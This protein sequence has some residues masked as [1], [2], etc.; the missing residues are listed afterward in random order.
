M[1]RGL[2]S[3]DH[4][5][6]MVEDPLSITM[7]VLALLRFQPSVST[8]LTPSNGGSL[9]DHSFAGAGMGSLRVLLDSPTEAMA[10]TGHSEDVM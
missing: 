7:A 2:V 10:N 5:A 6:R 1:T 9:S 8:G 3:K 4:P